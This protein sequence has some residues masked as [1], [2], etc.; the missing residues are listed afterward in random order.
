[1]IH[2]QDKAL[3]RKLYKKDGSHPSTHGGY[4][5]ACVLWGSLTGK[6]P[7]VI[8]W[9]GSLKAGEAKFLRSVASKAVK[10]NNP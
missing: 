6:D 5:A 1:M 4:L 3:F 8:R 2:S 9:N 7:N 10:Q